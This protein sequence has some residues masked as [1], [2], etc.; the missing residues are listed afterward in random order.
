MTSFISTKDLRETSRQI[1]FD[2]VLNI[3]SQILV[4]FGAL[5][6]S[7]DLCGLVKG[8]YGLVFARYR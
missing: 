4:G 3:K 5:W 6:M 7:L 1:T 8:G 2:R